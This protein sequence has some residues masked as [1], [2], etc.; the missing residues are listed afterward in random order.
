MILATPSRS[1]GPPRE[2]AVLP[3]L[4]VAAEATLTYSKAAHEVAAELARA[5]LEERL[6]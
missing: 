1:A 5:F 6:K 2:G 3:V 4:A